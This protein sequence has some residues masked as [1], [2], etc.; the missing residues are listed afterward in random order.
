MVQ[1]NE[2]PG[3][4]VIELGYGPSAIAS[5]W[6]L[7]IWTMLRRSQH[8]LLYVLFPWHVASACDTHV[9]HILFFRRHFPF[10]ASYTTLNLLEHGDP[11]PQSQQEM[12]NDKHVHATWIEGSHTNGKPGMR[13]PTWRYLHHA[14]GMTGVFAL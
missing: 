11:Q 1:K 2:K 4:I 7:T 10:P 8:S 3:I 5:C 14:A 9:D 13:L 12:G 6:R